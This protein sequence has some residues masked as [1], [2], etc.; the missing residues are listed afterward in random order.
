[1]LEPTGPAYPV[2]QPLQDVN[3]YEC[4]LVEALLVP[5]DLDRHQATSLVINA[6][7]DLA[8]TAFP[9][10]VD[11]LVPIRQMITYNDIIVPPL[12]VISKICSFS[13]QVSY[14]LLG[15]LCTAKIDIVVVNDFSAFEYIQVRHSQC[16]T[17]A[18]AFLCCRSPA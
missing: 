5:D 10:D 1:M 9:E 8:K 14:V 15:V 16:L 11:Y 6:P 7:C 13:I 2:S 17:G 3:F 18:H 12:I 4:L